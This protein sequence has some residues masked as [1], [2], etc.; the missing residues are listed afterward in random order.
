MIQY[1][2]LAA[3][4]VVG[5]TAPSSGVPEELHDLLKT[6]SMRL[7]RQGHEVIIQETAWT[8]ESVRSAPAAKRAEEFH[9]LMKNDKVGLILPPWG[10]ELL[11]EALEFI[12][13][14]DLKNKWVLG[15]SDTSTLL[16]AIT[17]QTGI[18]T[19]HGTNLIDLRGEY[20]DLTTGMWKKVLSTQRG[21]F[22][23]Q[24]SSSHYQKQWKHDEPSPC[25]FHLTELTEW[26]TVSGKPAVMKGRLLGGC[27]DTIRHLIGTP[28]GDVKSFRNTYLPGKPLLWYME[29]CELSP[30]DLRRSLVQMKYAGWFENCG[31]VLFGRSAVNASVD[32]YSAENV[33]REL[34]EELGV[35]VVYDIDCGH[36]PP[37]IT[38]INGAWAEAEVDPA[39]KGTILQHF[40]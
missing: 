17:L 28:Y 21:S 14:A 30:T 29:N 39:G 9:E 25:V 1:P 5:V 4:A 34:A 22:I 36:Q 24:T 27:V 16:L 6:A 26:K 40:I 12:N 31:G 10:G 2:V 19:A 33:Y 32:G 35:P 7:R 3:D 37:Q 13:F 23:L 11:I 20:T 18:A 8:Q 15:Y 38:F